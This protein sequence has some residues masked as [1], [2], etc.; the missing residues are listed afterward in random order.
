MIVFSTGS[1]YLIELVLP[2]CQR[3]D[4]V[5]RTIATVSGVNADLSAAVTSAGV[6]DLHQLQSVN[7]GMVAV[8]KDRSTAPVVMCHPI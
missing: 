4:G 2:G 5:N 1:K 7:G 8:F 3:R 6:A